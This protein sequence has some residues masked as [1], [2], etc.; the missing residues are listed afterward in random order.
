MRGGQAHFAF[1]RSG[2]EVAQFFAGSPVGRVD[3]RWTFQAQPYG[4]I[5]PQDLTIWENSPSGERRLECRLAGQ[6]PTS[7]RPYP[8]WKHAV[9]QIPSGSY[10]RQVVVLLRD[11]SDHFH[12]RLLSTEDLHRLPQQ[13]A[14]AML[15]SRN[16]GRQ[17]FSSESGEFVDLPPPRSAPDDGVSG[18]V[19]GPENTKPKPRSDDLWASLADFVRRT[20]GRTRARRVE[21]MERRTLRDSQVRSVALRCFGE[22]CQVRG[23]EFTIGLQ[24]EHL[25]LVLEVHHLKGVARGGSDSPFNLAVLCANHHRLCEG[26]PGVEAV[27]VSGSDDVLI[28]YT[29]GSFLIE[30]DLTSLRE[31]LQ[32][33]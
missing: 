21:R 24:R 14:A 10:P 2:E 20:E 19:T 32:D 26:L 9:L 27:E 4:D 15:A 12:I 18:L 11:L 33:L 17:H 1:G 22:R 16:T 7:R 5:S 28:R 25:G 6:S 8:L 30:R 29:D 3:R 23:C 13:T 31:Q